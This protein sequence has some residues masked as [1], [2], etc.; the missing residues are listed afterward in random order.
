[1]AFGIGGSKSSS[2]SQSTAQSSGFSIAS[3]LGKSEQD[4]AFKDLFASLYGGASGAA[5]AVDLPTYKNEASM[6]F[7]GGTNFLQ[8]LGGGAGADYLEGRISGDG[9]VLNAQIEELRTSL[10][11]NF[12]ESVL[13]SIR[14]GAIAGGTFGGG[15]EG[16][17][18]GIAARDVGRNLQSGVVSLLT[19]D[20]AGKD[21]AAVNLQG[22]QQQGAATGIGGLKDLLGLS[23]A[24]AGADLLPYQLLAQIMGGPTTLTQSLQTSSSI[25]ADQSTAQSTSSAKSGSF[26]FGM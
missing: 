17:A 2:K 21:A 7:Q 26:S 5:G 9:S 19:A 10:M 24:G 15:R 1:M 8:S 16:V 22:L 4:I 14:S 6:L 11:E 12:N 3:S 18:T 25:S 13:P 23:Q 20:Q